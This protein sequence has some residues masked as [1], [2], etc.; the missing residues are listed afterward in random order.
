MA[1]TAWR[2]PARPRLLQIRRHGGG[3]GPAGWEGWR[4]GGVGRAA[5]R[6]AC[7]Q[8]ARPRLRQIRRRY[9]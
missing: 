1:R 4:P 2:R 9:G 3:C 6:T 8:P 5:A 7:R